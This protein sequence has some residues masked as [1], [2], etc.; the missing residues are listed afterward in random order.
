MLD[1]TPNLKEGFIETDI[2][3]K[4]TDSHLYLPYSSSHPQHCKRAVPYGVALRLNRNWSSEKVR[5]KRT[6]EYKMYLKR[7]SYPKLLVES[8]FK[9]AFKIKRS[10][11]LHPKAKKR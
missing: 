3:S 5:D 11:L 9:K 4:P 1:L 10:E 7:L 8:K 2:Y 6:N